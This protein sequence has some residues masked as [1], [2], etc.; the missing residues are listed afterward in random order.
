MRKNRPLGDREKLL[1]KVRRFEP[2]QPSEVLQANVGNSRATQPQRL[3][4]CQRSD[5]L[6]SNVGDALPPDVERFEAP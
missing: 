5:V 3:K 4:L 1:A 6:Q 2:G